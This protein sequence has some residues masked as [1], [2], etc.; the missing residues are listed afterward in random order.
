MLYASVG[1]VGQP[2]DR[3]PRACFVTFDGATLAYHRVDYPFE[4]TA[5]K[6]LA[7]GLP[8]MLAD[9]LAVGR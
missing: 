3:D 8:A 1:S 2:R 6:I 7:L 4:I 9:R 5:G